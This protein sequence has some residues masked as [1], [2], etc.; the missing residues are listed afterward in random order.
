MST[1]PKPTLVK[2]ISKQ[3]LQVFDF[4]ALGV[5]NVFQDATSWMEKDENLQEMIQSI[6]FTYA[7]QLNMTWD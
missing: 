5:G 2:L 3:L 7:R 1:I 4:N 6:H